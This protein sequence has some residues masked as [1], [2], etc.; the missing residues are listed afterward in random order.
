MKPAPA[1]RPALPAVHPLRRRRPH[2]LDFVARVVLA[3]FVLTLFL[4]A[5]HA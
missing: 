5:V 2:P 4:I 3:L 1:T